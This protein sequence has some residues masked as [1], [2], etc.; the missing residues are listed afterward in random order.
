MVARWRA[1]CR[2]NL[3][4]LS[5][6]TER[7]PQVHA[8][9]LSRLLAGVLI[10]CGINTAFDPLCS[11]VM[12]G[13][14]ATLEE[15]AQLALE[16]RK[17]TGELILSRELTTVAIDSDATFDPD[18]MDDEWAGPNQPPSRVTENV[19]CTTQLGLL[20]EEK[21]SGVLHSVVLEKPKVVLRSALEQLTHELSQPTADSLGR[22]QNGMS[23]SFKALRIVYADETH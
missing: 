16:L 14:G 23:F 1:L 8:V 6:A 3:D 4:E 12:S 5:E 10:A 7:Q 21:R 11:S 18:H 13:F 9:K 19:V 22:G 17:I 2:S 15:I 20:K